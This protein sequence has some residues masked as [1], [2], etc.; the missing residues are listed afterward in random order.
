MLCAKCEKQIDDDDIFCGYCG[1]NQAKYKKYLEKV[2]NKV[3]KE[4]DKEYNTK[5]RNAQNKLKQ[6][7]SS[8]EREIQR[9]ANSRWQSIG[10]K[11]FSY[12]MTEGKI[13]VNGSTYLFSDIKGAEIVKQDSFRTITNTTETGKSKSKKHAS[14][15][16][17]LLGAA[18]AGPVGAVVGG[19]VLGKTTQKGKTNTVTN[20]NDIPTCYHIGVNVNLNG[21]NTEIVLLSRTVDQ[22]SAI[23]N[24]TVKNAQLI[25][26][27]LRN[28]SQTPVPKKYLQPE[29]EQSVLNIEKEIEEAAKELKTV[30]DDKPTYEIPESYLK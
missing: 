13:I 26:D 12:N 3:H 25:V 29:E 9:I 8:R 21:F 2:N 18:V 11:S 4:Q 10:D 23:H 27:K 28:L 16:G 22:S 6:L 15:G 1:I 17:G 5:V 20:S 30:S 24:N 14:L 19:S 7:Q